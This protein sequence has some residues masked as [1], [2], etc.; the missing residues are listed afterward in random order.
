MENYF[1]WIYVAE[2]LPSKGIAVSFSINWLCACI[3]LIP[4]F[5]GTWKYPEGEKDQEFINNI[6]FPNAIF[7][8]TFL[9]LVKIEL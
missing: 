1:R 5:I 4:G 9:A 7:C 2:I 3:S 6:L 8:A